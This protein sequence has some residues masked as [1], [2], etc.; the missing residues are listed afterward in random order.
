MQRRPSQKLLDLIH[1]PTPFR[2][3]R[4]HTTGNNSEYQTCHATELP[5]MSTRGQGATHQQ[6]KSEVTCDKLQNKELVKKETM[7]AMDLCR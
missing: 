5:L 2:S 4:P 1:H 7:A 6:P 3:L